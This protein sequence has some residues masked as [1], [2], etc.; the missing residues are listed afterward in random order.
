MELRAL[1]GDQKML[2]VLVDAAR[3]GWGM[4]SVCILGF[5]TRPDRIFG[6]LNG[7]FVNA[8]VGMRCAFSAEVSL[9]GVAD[10]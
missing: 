1:L 6:L 2:A 8:T 10:T 5:I 4:Y 9:Y 7:L 3:M